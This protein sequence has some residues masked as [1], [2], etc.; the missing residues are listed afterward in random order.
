MRWDW[1][2]GNDLKDEALLIE[3]GR[4][5]RFDG[6]EMDVLQIESDILLDG[7][8]EGWKGV[9]QWQSLRT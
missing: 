9:N 7:R 5:K 6:R 8:K 3:R 4:E 2:C 1:R